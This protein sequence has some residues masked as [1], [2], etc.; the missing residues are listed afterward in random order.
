MQNR[1]HDSLST[2]ILRV[3]GLALIVTLT[4]LICWMFYIERNEI[5]ELAKKRAHT[6]LDMLE[7]VHVNSMLYREQTEDNDPAIDTLNG[8]MAQFSKQSEG[9][10]IWLVMNQ[11]VIA[12]QKKNGQTEIEGPQDSVDWETMRT[13]ETV[14]RLI[15]G[16]K[17]RVT[18]P[19][20]LG[21]GSANHQKCFAC[22]ADLMG[23]EKGETFGAYSAEVDIAAPLLAWQKNALINSA[24][25]V[26]I[27]LLILGT[28]YSLL[29]GTVVHPLSKIADAADA[30][31]QGRNQGEIDGQ[32]RDDTVGRLARALKVIQ[33]TR[34]GLH[35]PAYPTGPAVQPVQPVSI[36]PPT[37]TEPSPI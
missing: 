20:I 8:T 30:V 10:K 13:G 1:E 15:D 34:S 2:K 37:Q 26:A 21:E 28:I 36:T 31:A 18:R 22:H 12:F 14:S 23:V 33:D 9:V 24:A 5:H 6:T 7:S 32:N 11:K 35:A 16:Q 19:V 25:A 3:V 29:I 4:P 17:I 27:I